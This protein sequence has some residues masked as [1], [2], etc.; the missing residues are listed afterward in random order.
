MEDVASNCFPRTVWNFVQ[1]KWFLLLIFLVSSTHVTLC[2][3]VTKISIHTRPI[4]CFTRMSQA[5][6]NSCV[7]TMESFVYLGPQAK[8]NKKL[9][10]TYNHA[11]LNVFLALQWEHSAHSNAVFFF[12]KRNIVNIFRRHVILSHCRAVE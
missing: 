6:F 4:D 2:Y 8:R 3:V 5:A 11:I 10:T 12:V 7:G 1:D 9:K